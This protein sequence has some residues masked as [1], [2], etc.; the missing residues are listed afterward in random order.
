MKVAINSQT[1]RIVS[2]DRIIID[3]HLEGGISS[4]YL[5]KILDGE[6][7]IEDVKHMKVDKSSID[8]VNIPFS[9][10]S[11]TDSIGS[12]I[13]YID[14]ETDVMKKLTLEVQ[15]T[16]YN[17]TPPQ[18]TSSVRSAIQREDE[19]T[20]VAFRKLFCGE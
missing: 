12:D 10:R 7:V 15:Y 1:F 3:Y 14:L 11:D 18:Y 2:D 5:M 13:N 19:L 20:K 6:D 16:Y 8:G 4:R 17:N 9:W